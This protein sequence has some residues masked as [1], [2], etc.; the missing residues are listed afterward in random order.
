MK[1]LPGIAAGALFAAAMAFTATP[2]KA[3]FLGKAGRITH[4]MVLRPGSEHY[5]PIQW[6]DAFALIG[7]HVRAAKH[8]DRVLYYTSGQIGRAHV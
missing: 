5:V 8:P 1:H 7:E 4:P 6:D 3:Q 2:A